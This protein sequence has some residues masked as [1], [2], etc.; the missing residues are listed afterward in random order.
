MPPLQ[1][2]LVFSKCAAHVFAYGLS[3]SYLRERTVEMLQ[4]SAGKMLGNQDSSL[5]WDTA[6]CSGQGWC[7]HV[8]DAASFPNFKLMLTGF[9]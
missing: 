1:L 8:W 2:S 4:V 9:L 3:M 7:G 6:E 5:V